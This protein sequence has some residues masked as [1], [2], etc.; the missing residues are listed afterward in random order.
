MSKLKDT[1]FAEVPYKKHVIEKELFERLQQQYSPVISNIIN[2]DVEFYRTNQTIRWKFGYDERVAI[3]AWCNRKTNIVTVNIAAVDFALQQNEPLDIEYFLL[4]EIRHIYQHLE[5]EDYRNDPTKCNNAELAKKWSEEEDNYVTA[6]NK[7]GK[8]NT[9]YFLQD[10]EMD[11]F[12]YAYAVMKYKYGE[13]KYLYL[14]EVY[15]NDEFDKIVNEWQ[16][17]FKNEGL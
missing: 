2:S 3:F 17:A 4:H 8:E 1:E 10:M 14:P 5:I 11:A 7:E 15:H 13:V 16:V 12:A 6:L 9:D